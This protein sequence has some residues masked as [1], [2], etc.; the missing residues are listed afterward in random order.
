MA[1]GDSFTIAISA[2]SGNY[3]E[4]IKTATDGSQN[5]IAVL[6]D[7]ADASGGSVSTA[8]YF[9]GEFNQD[10]VIFDASWTLS[11]LASIL[12]PY[13]IILKAMTGDLSATDAT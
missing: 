7:D 6:A 11:G 9:M 4:S 2:G 10:A 3:V 1:A 12:K 5:P 13:K 8:A